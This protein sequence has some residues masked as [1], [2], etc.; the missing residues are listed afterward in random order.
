MVGRQLGEEVVG[1]VVG[2]PAA[3]GGGGQRRWLGEEVVGGG[4]GLGRW[5]SAYS[6]GRRWSVASS[7]GEDA[8]VSVV[9][10]L[11]RRW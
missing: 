1:G 9:D 6:S 2:R 4:G 3:S 10:G 7:V 5:W 11:E 8:G